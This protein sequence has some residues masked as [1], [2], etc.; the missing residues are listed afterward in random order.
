MGDH[1][2]GPEDFEAA[3]GPLRSTGGAPENTERCGGH[4]EGKKKDEKEKRKKNQKLLE[5]QKMKNAKTNNI[6]INKNI[7]ITYL[8]SII[9]Y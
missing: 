8:L 2:E 4:Q 5:T 9:I 3:G 1:E 6:M 7:K